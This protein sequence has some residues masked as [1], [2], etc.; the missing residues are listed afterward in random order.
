MISI[1]FLRKCCGRYVLCGYVL[2]DVDLANLNDW[3]S[4]MGLQF[5]NL[6]LNNLPKILKILS[7][8]GE[9]LLSASPYFQNA[10]KRKHGVQVDLLIQTKFTYYIVEIKFRQKIGRSVIDEV[11]QKISK[12]SIPKTVSVRPVL[13]YQGV[14]SKNIINENFFSALIS[15]DQLLR[16]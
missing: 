5:E 12:L 4:V 11:V 16:V 3:L 14:L 9:S 6:V 13:I 2:C 10:T 7:I 15:F 1:K 8:S